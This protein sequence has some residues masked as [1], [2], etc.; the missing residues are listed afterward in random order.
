MAEGP[1]DRSVWRSRVVQSPDARPHRV[2]CGNLSAN[3]TVIGDEVAGELT[4]LK[5]Q[6][7]GDLLLLC[8]PS[9]FAQLT[10]QRLI[11]EYMLY[12]CPSAL[13]QGTHLFRDITAP[14]KLG[15]ERSVPFRTGVNL[16][17]YS[18]V[19]E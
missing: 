11:D 9:L 6:P 10:C 19:Y 17:F 14:L 7:G 16:H 12:M 4:R 8:G 13:G 15:F 3:S 18:P 5:E 2:A 1:F